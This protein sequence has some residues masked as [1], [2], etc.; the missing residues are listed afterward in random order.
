MA[1][2]DLGGN[3]RL[4]IAVGNIGIVVGVLLNNGD[5]TFQ[6]PV[7]YNVGTGWPV[8]IAIGDVNG[9]G[10]QDVLVARYAEVVGVLL[11]TGHGTFARSAGI[12]TGAGGYVLS[13][14]LADLN[15][16]G[17]FDLVAAKAASSS[18]VGVRLNATPAITTTS[19]TS[20]PN[21]SLLGQS[22]TFT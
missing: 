15:H 12:S 16:D 1:L 7:T 10:K 13:V 11:G 19:M 5:G 22:V 20:A 21:P 3:G 8:G 18:I 17:K 2:G 6:S 9:D 14:A 4:D